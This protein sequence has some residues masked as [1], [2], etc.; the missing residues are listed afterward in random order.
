MLLAQIFKTSE[1]ARKRAAFENAHLSNR[2]Q[3][4]RLAYFVVRFLDGKR[5][6][7]PYSPAASSSGR[8]HWQLERRKREED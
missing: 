5:D 4:S 7:A 8:Y 3:A 2:A 1:G 6:Y